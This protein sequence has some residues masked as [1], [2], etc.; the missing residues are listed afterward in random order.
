MKSTFFQI[1]KNA[2]FL[3]FFRNQLNGIDMN[4]ILIFGINEDVI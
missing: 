1:Y 3:Q 2:M 4:L